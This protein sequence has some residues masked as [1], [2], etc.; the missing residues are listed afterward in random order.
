MHTTVYTVL[1]TS[2]PLAAK[3]VKVKEM[4]KKPFSLN[5]VYQLILHAIHSVIYVYAKAT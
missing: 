2:C 1:S 5:G 3:T 4:A